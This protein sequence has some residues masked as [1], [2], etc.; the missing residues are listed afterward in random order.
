[1]LPGVVLAGVHDL[2][3]D[4]FFLIYSFYFEII[5][6]SHAVVRT[7]TESFPCTPYPVSPHGNILCFQECGVDGIIQHV[8]LELAFFPSAK[9]SQNSSSCC[10]L[11]VYSFQLPRSIPRYRC[12]PFV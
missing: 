1:M 3:W 9:L 10:I 5:I 8:S 7:N 4:F 2:T 11:K 12:L 6:E